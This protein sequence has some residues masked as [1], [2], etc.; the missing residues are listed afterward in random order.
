MSESGSLH[1]D[2]RKRPGAWYDEDPFDE[3][4]FAAGAIA[5]LVGAGIGVALAVS[6]VALLGWWWAP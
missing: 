1:K 5:S 3:P 6:L 4:S 2:G